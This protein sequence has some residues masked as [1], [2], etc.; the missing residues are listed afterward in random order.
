VRT[1]HEELLLR[2]P[3]LGASAF[4][5]LSRAFSDSSSGRAPDLPYFFIASAM[6]FHHS[7]VE[8]VRRMQF[9]S[10]IL[11]AVYERP[12][13]V[14]GLQARM[15]QYSL[16]ALK[17]LQVGATSGI[18]QREGGE[19]FPTFRA[20]GPNLPKAVRHGEASVPDIFN[21][22]KRLG[23]WFAAEGFEKLRGQLNI[24]F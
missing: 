2:N 19:G 16:A 18:L 14:A 11:K 6:I 21:C 10:G 13:I 7:T 9:D 15:E 1:D 5:H 22:A 24:E 3:A 4:W 12:D 20:C 23:T 17:A 8:K